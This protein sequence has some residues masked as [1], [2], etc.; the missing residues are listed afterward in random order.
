VRALSGVACAFAL[1]DWFGLAQRPGSMAQT[2]CFGL[3]LGCAYA[4]LPG[5]A[6]GGERFA[7]L[8]ACAVLASVA[9]PLAHAFPAPV[10]PDTLGAYHAAA[11]LDSAAVW[12]AEQRW[13]GLY[14]TV[15]AWGALRALPLTGGLIFACAA[16]LAARE[17]RF[18]R[19]AFPR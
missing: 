13:S 2:A 12:A 5:P 18:S 6:R 1:V 19:A 16:L 3:A 14:A 7:A 17:E 4:V 11:R 15:P 9:L 10:W 8:A